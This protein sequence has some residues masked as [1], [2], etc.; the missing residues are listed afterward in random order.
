VSDSVI[1]VPF[2]EIGRM[3]D[4]ELDGLPFGAIQLDAGGTI[5][6]FNRKES[7]LSGRA[8]ESVVGKN[9]FTEVAPC[10]NVQNFAGRFR[11]GIAAEQLNAVFPYRFDF[12]MV[13]RDV[14]ITL[15]YS[16]ATRTAW[17]FVVDA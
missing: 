4:G 7:E 8:R 13:P 17:V 1:G 10:T 6:S 14:T 3:T 16:D 11:D 15:F 2:E 9:F 12:K 5:L